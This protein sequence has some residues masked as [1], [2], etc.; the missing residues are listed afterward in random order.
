MCV[1]ERVECRRLLMNNWD[2]PTVRHVRSSRGHSIWTIAF[3]LSRTLPESLL[4]KN[5]S[6][7]S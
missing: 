5:N 3:V 7:S 4:T 6:L 2:L 1:A